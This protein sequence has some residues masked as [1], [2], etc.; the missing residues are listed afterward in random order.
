MGLRGLVW[1]Q[2]GTTGSGGRKLAM[3]FEAPSSQIASA[4]T[5]AIQSRQALWGRN[6]CL[7]QAKNAVQ[8]HPAAYQP[9]Q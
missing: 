7:Q 2:S 3:I 6:V 8:Q 5:G 1:V 9:D 4:K